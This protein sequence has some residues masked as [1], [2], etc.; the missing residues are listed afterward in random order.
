MIVVNARSSAGPAERFRATRIDR[1]DPGPADVLI[2]IA[3]SGIC[4]TDVSRTRGEFGTT[5]YPIVP[6]H[7][8][9]GIIV[10]TGPEVTRFAV[11]DRVGVGCLVDSC[12]QCDYCRAGLEPYCRRD[13]IR[14]YNSIG[15]DGQKTLGGYSEKIV[16]DEAYVVRIPD[17][18]PLANAAPLLCAG[19]TLYSPLRHWQAGPGKKVAILGFGGLGHVGVSISAA[20]GA[21]TTVFELTMDKQAD[22]LKRGAEDY[23]LSTDPAIFTEFAGAFDLIVSTV[24]AP[25][26]YDAF[27]GLLALDGTMVMLGVPKKP[28]TLDVFSLLYNRR[29]LAG[30][31]VGGIAET[32]AML[33]FCAERG[34]HADVEIISA[35]EIDDAYDRVAAGDVRYRFVIDV[36]TMANG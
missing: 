8:I 21:H 27:L 13:H 14:T 34:I 4:H 16:V 35:D 30:T 17:A 9:A 6:G 18:I 3:Y 23:R 33:D 15:R 28:I 31:L 7:E 10:A 25:I 20:L 22:A 32:Q 29:S 12:R 24:P 36:R 19:I 1:R 11:G 5:M 26:D 2:D